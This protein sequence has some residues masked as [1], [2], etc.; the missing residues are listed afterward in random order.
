MPLRTVPGTYCTGTA[1]STVRIYATAAY[2]A[3][4]AESRVDD[5]RSRFFVPEGHTI[6]L[7]V[8]LVP[9]SLRIRREFCFRRRNFPGISITPRIQYSAVRT[10]RKLKPAGFN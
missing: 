7:L 4:H 6:S 3:L 1:D 9:V 10:R 8:F 5:H 2:G